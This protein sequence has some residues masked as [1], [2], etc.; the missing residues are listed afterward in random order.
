MIAYQH[1]CCLWRDKHTR[2]HVGRKQVPKNIS[3]MSPVNPGLSVVA[4]GVS[5]F[6]RICLCLCAALE[7]EWGDG[8]NAIE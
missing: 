4:S 5:G 7:D 1:T 6:Q 3:H 2:T 8:G